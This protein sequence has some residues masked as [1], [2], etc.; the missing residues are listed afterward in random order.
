[1][2][3]PLRSILVHLLGR[4]GSIKDTVG[5]KTAAAI[6]R[7]ILARCP[8]CSGQLNG[9]EHWRVAA[10]IVDSDEASKVAILVAA[11]RWEE[12]ARETHWAHDKDVREYHA[13]RCPVANGMGLVTAVFTHEFWSRDHVED[14]RALSRVEA[15]RL[16]E[17]AQNRWLA[18]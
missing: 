15:A 5:E 13:L 14:V 17:L 9:H 18:L 7:G 6:L 12:A 11:G 10:V 8:V 4:P 1:M 2:F 3:N 16:T